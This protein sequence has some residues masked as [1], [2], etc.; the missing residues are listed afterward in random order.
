MITQEKLHELFEYRDDGTL[1]RKVNIQSMAR[2]GD[3]AGS[4]GGDG[5][6]RISIDYKRYLLH[7]LIFLYHYGY[8]THGLQIDHIDADK[9][10]NRID[11]LREVTGS[12]NMYNS[13]I[14]SNNK[15]GV[16]GVY[17]NE[18]RRKWYPQIKVNG[19]YVLRGYYDTIEEAKAVIEKARDELHGDFA[20]HN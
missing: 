14:R 16:K 11:N 20:R 18:A 2:K 10:N 6:T 4:V 9:S 17:W 13:K 19:K 8:L 1:I 5:Y 7:R 15:S 3:A 12:Q